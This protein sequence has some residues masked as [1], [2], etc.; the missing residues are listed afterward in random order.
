MNAL[1]LAYATRKFSESSYN[2]YKRVVGKMNK[3]LNPNKNEDFDLMGA[4]MDY[5]K[6]VKVLSDM[7]YSTSQQM[8]STILLLLSPQQRKSPSPSMLPLYNKYNDLLKNE[9]VKHKSVGNIKTEKEKKNWI[10][11]NM[12]QNNYL[13]PY[14]RK[15]K[16]IDLSNP[17]SSD[18][19]TVFKTL[20]LS[21]YMYLPPRRLEYSNV[22]IMLKKDYSK[23]PK[24]T[25]N[26]NN[27][28]VIQKSP[29]FFSW[30]DVKSPTLEAVVVKIPKEL[31]SVLNI[32]M[33]INSKKSGDNLLTIGGKSIT[34][35]RLTKELNK[36]FA[37]TKIS[38]SMLRKI[39]LTHKYGDVKTGQGLDAEMMNHSI[40]VQQNE[41]VKDD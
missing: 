41:Y 28:M 31:K 32:Y 18:K 13:K 29:L 14:V 36:I 25:K 12:I 15:S 20:L 2:T 10:D 9:Q 3:L 5:N 22:S 23:L 35:N 38:A 11:Y 40:S 26:S 6:V 34:S 33:K 19:D 37:P 17:T 39:Y 27:Y 30:G 4:I 21:L 7:S 1:N 16:K 8:I 24:E